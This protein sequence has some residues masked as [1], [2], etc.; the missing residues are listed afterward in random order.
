M[1]FRIVNSILTYLIFIKLFI[2]KKCCKKKPVKNQTVKEIKLLLSNNE[3]D[4]I[5]NSIQINKLLENGW[6]SI[7]SYNKD[8]ILIDISFSYNDSIYNIL[9]KYP[10]TFT[11]PLKF[12]EID[13]DKKILFITDSNELELDPCFKKYLGPQN[14]FYINNNVRFSIKDIADMNK[15]KVPKDVIITFYNLNNY[16]ININENIIDMIKDKKD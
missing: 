12:K 1:C 10:E 4:S 15:I 8:V 14:D 2:T 6:Y 13:F 7:K 11:F 3:I 5:T 16:I 9:F